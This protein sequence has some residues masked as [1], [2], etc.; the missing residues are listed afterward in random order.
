MV[1]TVRDILIIVLA[2]ESIVLG[3]FLGLVLWQIWKLV[4][5]IREE[6]TPLLDTTKESVEEITHTTQFVGRSV[7]APFVKAQAWAAG[8]REAVRTVRESRRQPRV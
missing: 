3:I 1:Q 2:L 6:V 8:L 7:A 4:K 5:L